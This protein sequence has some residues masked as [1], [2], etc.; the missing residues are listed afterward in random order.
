M[1]GCVGG[2][3]NT[4]SNRSRQEGLGASSMAGSGS[5]ESGGFGAT[6]STLYGSCLTRACFLTG[7]SAG[8]CGSCPGAKLY[9]SSVSA[10]GC[11]GGAGGSRSQS[12]GGA[13][14]L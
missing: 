11:L 7:S 9:V 12:S 5:T 8:L 14:K 3:G 4:S 13:L 6:G 1:N 2:G 10:R